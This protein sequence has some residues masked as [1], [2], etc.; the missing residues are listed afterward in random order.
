M[1]DILDFKRPRYTTVR[2]WNGRYI[3]ADNLEGEAIDVCDTLEDAQ[4]Y[5]AD[6]NGGAA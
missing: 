6:L 2:N 3:V 4:D 1:T 5:A